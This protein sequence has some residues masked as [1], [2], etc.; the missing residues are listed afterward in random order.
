MQQERTGNA[1]NDINM[2]HVDMCVLIIIIGMCCTFE[3]CAYD[4][5]CFRSFGISVS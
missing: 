5:I 2:I 1:Q 3:T 4:M